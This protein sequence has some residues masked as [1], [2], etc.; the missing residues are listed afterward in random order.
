M[1]E[2]C[3]YVCVSWNKDKKFY[4]YFFFR[5]FFFQYINKIKWKNIRFQ[6]LKRNN[7]NHF[8]NFIYT[9]STV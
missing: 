2:I 6:Y 8:N 4:E 3:M 5:Y 9:R 1:Q 7:L